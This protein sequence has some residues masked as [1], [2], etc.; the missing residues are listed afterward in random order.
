VNDYKVNGGM[1]YIVP[2]SKRGDPLEITNILKQHN[3]TYTKATPS[4]YSLWLQY[5]FQ[6]LQ[7]ASSWQFAFGGGETLTSTILR[8]FRALDLPQLRFFNSY[9]PTE[10]TISSHK[11]EIAYRDE[12][13]DGRIPCGYSL[14]NYVTYILDEQLKPVPCG[15][16]GDVFIGGSGVADGYLNNKDLTEKMFLSD[17]FAIDDHRYASNGWTRMYRTGDIGHLNRDG[18]LVFHNRIAGDT[19]VKIRGLRIELSDIESNIVSMANGVLRE[20]VVTL[21]E[22][23]TLVA[24]VVFAALNDR[25]K[26][27]EFLHGLLSRLP[28]PQYM[29]P[30]VAIPLERLPLSSHSKVDRK[31]IQNLPLP[32]RIETPTSFGELAY[33][34]QTETMKKLRAVWEDVLGNQSRFSLNPTTSFFAVGGNSLLIVRLQSRIRSVFNVSIRL[35]EL[36]GANKLADMARLI[37]ESS[38]VEVIDWDKETALPDLVVQKLSVTETIQPT[39]SNPKTVLITGATGFL[40]KHILPQLA[41]DSN[42]SKIYCVAVRDKASKSAITGPKTILYEGDLILP[43]L[44]LSEA[45]FETLSNEVDVILHMGATRS[46]WDSYHTLRPTNVNATKEVVKLAAARRIPIHYTSSAGV[47]K[48][49]ENSASSAAAN[50]PPIDGSNGYV[51]SKWASERILEHAA[52]TLGL[53]VSIHR[54]VPSNKPDQL[55]ANA[56][57]VLQEFLRFVDLSKLVP[58]LDGWDGRIDLMPAEDAA[59]R[60]SNAVVHENFEGIQGAEYIHHECELSVDVE[61]T[62]TYLQKQRGREGFEKMAGVRWTG[63]IKALGFGYL[64]ASQNVNVTTRETELKLESRR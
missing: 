57:L 8:D 11:T 14:P 2:W 60:L 33:T 52:E 61:D 44:G 20:A 17:P 58:D 41:K 34:E 1:I 28:L 21:R 26:K 64:F 23:D 5:G 40:A 24:H 47:L 48:R 39:R 25:T 49:S 46:F 56:H 3:I 12:V 7:L 19:Q 43:R 36:L 62:K 16:P 55:A 4:E 35:V 42:V 6:N 31:A 53:H 10:I 51:A 15:M 30:V 37:D 54:F 63:K 32:H 38:V 9:G 50:V 45:I 13:P 29:I 27:E 22:D 18:A 59:S